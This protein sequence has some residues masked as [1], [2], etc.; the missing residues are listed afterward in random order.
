MYH[1]LMNTTFRKRAVNV[2]F[3]LKATEVLRC[4]K[5]LLWADAVEK[6]ARDHRRIVIPSP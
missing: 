4:R 1:V 5:V 2:R 3:A 6:V